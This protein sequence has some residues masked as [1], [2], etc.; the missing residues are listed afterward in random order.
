MALKDWIPNYVSA[1]AG[2]WN[3]DGVPTK[4]FGDNVAICLA[5]MV[6]LEEEMSECICE[7]WKTTD[8]LR[9][10]DIASFPFELQQALFESGG[11][12]AEKWAKSH[13]LLKRLN[14]VPECCTATAIKAPSAYGVALDIPGFTLAANPLEHPLKFLGKIKIGD[15]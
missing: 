11:L 6:G 8:S 9:A 1:R 3:L 4:Y 13:L 7:H 10:I 15:C 2:R 5:E 14:L 12:P